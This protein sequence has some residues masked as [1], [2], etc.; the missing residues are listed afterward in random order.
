MEHQTGAKLGKEYIKAVYYHLAYLTYMQSTSCKM[1]GWM[2]QKLESRLTYWR[3]VNN[4]RYS[5]DTTLVAEREEELKSI[6]M[7]VKEENEKVGLKLNNQK[8]K[9]IVSGPITSWQID[10]GNNG[11]GGRLYFGGLQNYCRRWLQL[12]NWKMLAPWKKSY[13]QH[14]QYIKK[15]RHYFANKVKDSIT[16]PSSQSYGFSSSHIWMWQLDYK[17]SWV[18]KY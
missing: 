5:D 17:E 12:W 3:N 10:G 16:L 8:T 2:K 11:N 7:K 1:P 13:D 18:L 4:L 9:I 15:Q 14:R 6:L